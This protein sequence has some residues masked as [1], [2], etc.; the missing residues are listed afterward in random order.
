MKFIGQILTNA[1]AIFIADYLIVGF[2]FEGGILMLLIAGLILG[3]INFLI[4]PILKLIS[5]PIIL[6][7]LGLFLIVINIFLLW[8]LDYLM[9]ELTIIGLS[10]YFWG[11]LTISIIN[12]TFGV[13]K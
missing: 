6:L 11:V 10:A 3:L 9:P 2:T 5:A 7:S 8:L 1:L 13:R 4:K 12:I